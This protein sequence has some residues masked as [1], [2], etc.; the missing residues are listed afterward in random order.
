MPDVENDM[1]EL[2]R[3][4]AEGYPLKISNDDWDNIAP[5]PEHNTGVAAAAHKVKNLKKYGTLLLLLSLFLF[6]AGFIANYSWNKKVS[7]LVSQSE[8]KI[9]GEK[10][11]GKD[12]NKI[13]K[14][15]AA[16]DKK[17]AGKKQLLSYTDDDDVKQNYLGTKNSASLS[18]KRK[19]MYNI[20]SSLRD[21]KRSEKILA[22]V[23]PGVNEKILLE[24]ISNDKVVI[25]KHDP[26]EYAGNDFVLNRTI[27]L[28]QL[29]CNKPDINSEKKAPVSNKEKV[30][31]QH[32]IY[33]GFM[34]G[35][36]FNQIKTQGLKKPG[37]DIGI[38]A[39]YQI[40]KSLSVETGLMYDRKYYFSSGEYFDMTKVSGIMPANMKVLS[41]EG[42]C[43]V[44][45]IP[46]KIKYNLSN[47]GKTNF[48]STAGISTYIITNEYNKYRTLTNG[49]EQNITGTY[50]NTSR[51]LAA[52]LDVSLGYENKI[53]SSGTIRIEPY[54]QMPLK[55]IGVGSL[56]VMTAG[57]HIGFTR[58][59][60]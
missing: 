58:P 29:P 18:K 35:A 28:K 8:R 3:R 7:P 6:I 4:A 46:V 45:E 60:H 14:A 15:V 59:I 20:F 32:G 56:P 53:G 49:T 54:L 51:Y 31:K 9:L 22:T 42:S 36:S 17:N 55:G 41:L 43:A 19:Y 34:F 52:A 39:G 24:K 12:N 10:I 21:H 47:K 23:E 25:Q 48:Y 5:L 30:K 11:K 33:L 26:S 38:V 1:D 40:N 16:P 2:F 27:S 44:F 50:N 13:T 37:Y 57:L